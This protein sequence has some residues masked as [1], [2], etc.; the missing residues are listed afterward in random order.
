LETDTNGPDFLLL[1]RSFL[2][3]KAPF[4]PR[5]LMVWLN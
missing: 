2:T 3:D 4:V 1:Q 5:Y